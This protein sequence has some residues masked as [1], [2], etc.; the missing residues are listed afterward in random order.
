MK[1]WSLGVGLLQLLSCR[2]DV[3]DDITAITAVQQIL[4]AYKSVQNGKNMASLKSLFLQNRKS[5]K[6]K[7]CNMASL[8]SLFVQNRKSAKLKSCNMASLES[9]LQ[10]LQINK[11]VSY[12]KASLRL[13]LC[14]TGNQQTG[15]LPHGTSGFADSTKTG[16]STKLEFTTW[17][18][19][20]C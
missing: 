15:S 5:A 6:L 18:L 14:K 20:I 17:H 3:R 8:K 7:S 13:L 11:L 4:Q 12:Y 9:F 10:K 16:N 1:D 19:W 2:Y